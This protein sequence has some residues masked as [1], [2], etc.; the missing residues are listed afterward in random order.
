MEAAL[1]HMCILL[2]HPATVVAANHLLVSLF[3]FT[4]EILYKIKQ[5]GQRRLLLNLRITYP[6]AVSD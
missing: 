5:V 1:N 4:N 2:K 3:R 6:V